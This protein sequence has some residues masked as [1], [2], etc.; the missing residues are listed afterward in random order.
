MNGFLWGAKIKA[1][2]N[3][4]WDESKERPEEGQEGSGLL[5]EKGLGTSEELGDLLGSARKA[6]HSLHVRAWKGR[7]GNACGEK[8]EIKKSKR[9]GKP[10]IR[11]SHVSSS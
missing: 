7:G 9:T 8:T 3:Q 1:K 5:T 6:G 2:G 10:S 11:G 4:G